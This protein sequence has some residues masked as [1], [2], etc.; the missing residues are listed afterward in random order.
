MY[1]IQ[2]ISHQ[3]NMLDDMGELLF[4]DVINANQYCAMIQVINTYEKTFN[5]NTNFDR[6]H[7]HGLIQNRVI[8]WF[9]QSF[10]IDLFDNVHTMYNHT[11]HEF[12]KKALNKIYIYVQDKRKKNGDCVSFGCIYND[13]IYCR[14]EKRVQQMEIFY[15]LLSNTTF[16]KKLYK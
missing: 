2:R 8:Y 15:P 16:V 9:Y 1:D 13:E 10:M 3:Y 4:K 14:F 12:R 6:F 5:L 7:V 11:Y